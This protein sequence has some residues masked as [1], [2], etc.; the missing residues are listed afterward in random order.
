MPN[1][2]GVAQGSVL[3]VL[4]IL[5]TNDFPA[6]LQ[7]VCET[8]MYADDT[9]L[10]LG[11]RDKDKLDIDAFVALEIAKQLCHINDLVIN[12][13]KTPQ[14]LFTTTNTNSYVIPEIETTNNGKCL[15]I[16]LYNLSWKPHGDK[17]YPKL[18]TSLYV[19]RR[20]KQISNI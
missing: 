18:S 16:I 15:G 14:I 7:D 12:A 20:V 4:Y 6:L 1:T 3:P 10:I 11:N 17:L 9:A 5:F 8:V 19:V 13:S 2:R